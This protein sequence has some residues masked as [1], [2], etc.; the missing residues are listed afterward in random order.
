MLNHPIIRV[1]VFKLHNIVNK[2]CIEVFKLDLCLLVL[3][4]KHILASAEKRRDG[5]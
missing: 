1:V 4:M 3:Y 5:R 2:V